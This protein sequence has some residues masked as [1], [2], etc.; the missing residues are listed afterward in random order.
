MT[1]FAHDA[2]TIF[3]DLTRARTRL[4]LTQQQVADAV[5]ISRRTFSKLE[6]GHV[7]PSLPLACQWARTVGMKLLIQQAETPG[8]GK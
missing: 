6:N 8:E 7:Q 2:L 4:G 5:G 1:G 3:R